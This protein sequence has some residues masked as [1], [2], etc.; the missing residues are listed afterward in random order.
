MA[1]SNRSRW[2]GLDPQDPL[3]RIKGRN[4]L[5]DI[6]NAR[7]DARRFWQP[8]DIEPRR[9]AG[10]DAAAEIGENRPVIGR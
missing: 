8:P 3:G 1:R 7:L 5:I 2:G 4:K 9:E 10:D 6:T